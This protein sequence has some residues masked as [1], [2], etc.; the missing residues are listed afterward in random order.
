MKCTKRFPLSIP[1]VSDIRSRMRGQGV[2]RTKTTDGRCVYQEFR[3]EN[4][5]PEG[6]SVFCKI[7]SRKGT[8]SDP[9][10]IDNRGTIHENQ[11]LRLKSLFKGFL[12]LYSS[13]SNLL[14]LECTTF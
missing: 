6:S 3:K 2:R 12:N 9:A 11:Y 4:L 13:Y 14:T 5:N 7:L 8:N 1:S 10:V